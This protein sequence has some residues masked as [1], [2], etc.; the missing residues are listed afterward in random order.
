[1]GKTLFDK[2]I[3]IAEVQ[4]ENFKL[5]AENKELRDKLSE[6]DFLI[7]DKTFGVAVCGDVMLNKME[8]EIVNTQIFQRLRKVKE[9][10]STYLVYPSATH[11]RFE[12]SLGAVKKAD[13]I[14]LKNRKNQHSQ[15]KEK[16]ITA[17]EEQIIR[18]LALLHD[19]GHMPFGHTIEDEFGVFKSHDKHQT[20]WEFF[21]GEFSEIGKIIIKHHGKQF[22]ERFFGLIKCDKNFEKRENDAF[23]YDIVSNTVC[24]DLLDYLER[25]CFYTNLKLKYHPRFLDYFFIK[26]VKNKETNKNERRI[27]IRIYKKGKEIRH[28]NIS[29]LIQLLRNRYYLGERVYYHH[30]KI[31]TGTILSGAV[32]R[33]KEARCFEKIQMPAALGLNDDNEKILENKIEDDQALYNIHEMGD[34]QLITYLKDLPKKGK[35]T[36]NQKLI[37]AAERLAKNF[38]NRFLYKEIIYKTK[39][40]LNIDDKLDIEPIDKGEYDK[41]KNKV[42]L[43][44]HNKLIKDG[45]YV[46][47]L[48]IEDT[49]CNYLGD[50]KSGDVL[51]YCPPFDMTMKLAKMKVVNNEGVDFELKDYNDVT[52]KEECES[53]IKKHQSLWALRV[54]VHPEFVDKKHKEY[55]SKYSEY[56]SYIK[57]YINWQLL[58]EPGSD[59]ENT[60]GKVFWDKIIRLRIHEIPEIN[61]NSS[62]INMSEADEKIKE[63]ALDFCANTNLKRELSDIDISI[64]SKFNISLK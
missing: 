37:A 53:I 35:S 7:P 25:D 46:N 21:L 55:Q 1:M 57:D 12:H 28:D 45:S 36:D 39:K 34:E 6:A 29:E 40:D 52:I 18:L 38:D 24:A 33:A 15:E 43:T 56:Q 27:A 50:M 51:I 32:A 16:S 10:G 54:F 64:K 22:Y 2:N 26:E 19:I 60:K 61:N 44:I 31:L 41:V 42:A 62:N 49:I 59:E 8:V 4:N 20:R 58:V 3:E 63:L 11:T 23:M 14:I 5:K 17:E 48:K 30:A 13:L 47:R 9:L